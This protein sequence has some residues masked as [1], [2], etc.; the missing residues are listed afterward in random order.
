MAQPFHAEVRRGTDVAVVVVQGDVGPSAPTAIRPLLSEALHEPA[1]ADL[2][3][4]LLGVTFI[5]RHG[6][7]IV[8]YARRAAAAQG[9]EFSLVAGPI[10][11]A[12]EREARP[13]RRVMKRRAGPR[14]IFV[15]CRLCWRR[16][17]LLAER[18]EIVEGKVV[19]RCQHCHS[20]FLVRADD[21]AAL[22]V[23]APS[24][25]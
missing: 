8:E 5:D 22:G 23:G 24:E 10:V 18:M 14:S 16:I 25:D 11:K 6:L 21:A 1:P 17:K 12:A 20:P 4:D 9:I 15:D 19:Y 3:L 7:A 13:D 2:V